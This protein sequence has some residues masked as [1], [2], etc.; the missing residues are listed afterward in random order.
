MNALRIS[1]S[2]QSRDWLR[3]TPN[4]RRY[5]HIGVGLSLLLHGVA[6]TLHFGSISRTQQAAPMLEVALVN[7]STDTEPLQA[8]ALGQA[9]L[10][11]GGDGEQGMARSPLPRTSPTADD[12]VLAAMRKRQAELEAMQQQLLTVLEAEQSVAQARPD[13]YPWPEADRPGQD[14]QDQEAQLRTARI[15]AL[16]EQI[17]TYTRQPRTHVYAPAVSPWPYAEYVEQW[18]TRMED[19]GTRHYPT[20]SQGRLYGV[21]QATVFIRADGSLEDIRIDQPARSSALNQ[22]ARRIVQLAAPF[23][24]LPPELAR[25]TDILAITRTWRFTNDTLHM[26]ATE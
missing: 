14:E 9:A 13:T 5:L 3:A 7:A 6:L 24:P 18:R 10:D 12:I 16:S 21:L 11:G 4:S 20:G 15:A 25:E 8:Q 1:P 2:R 19:I 23:P 22:A 17:Q 26:Q